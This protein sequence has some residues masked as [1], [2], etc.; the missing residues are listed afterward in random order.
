GSYRCNCKEGFKQAS[1]GRACIDIDECLE[2]PGICHH[3]C[4]NIWGGHQ[5]T[6]NAG[7]NLAVD[8]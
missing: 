8:N 6:C 1:D 4:I 2:R 5:C 7:Y 3:N